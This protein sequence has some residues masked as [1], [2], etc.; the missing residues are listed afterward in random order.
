MTLQPL[1]IEGACLGQSQTK[2]EAKAL[3]QAHGGAI[4]AHPCPLP[5]ATVQMDWGLPRGAG[6]RSG[7]TVK[8][9]MC[10]LMGPTTYNGLDYSQFTEL[11]NE[12]HHKK[13][14]TAQLTRYVHGYLLGCNHLESMMLGIMHR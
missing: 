12:P 2:E 3:I 1:Q 10:T 6:K 7:G 5:I 14:N 4:L 11:R 8:G 9:G 13:M